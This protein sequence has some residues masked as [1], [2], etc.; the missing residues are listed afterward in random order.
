MA[1]GRE[2]GHEGH[3][4]TRPGGDLT[5]EVRRA[6]KIERHRDYAGAQTAEERQHPLGA[7]GTPKQRPVALGQPAALEQSGHLPGAL[8][9]VPIGPPLVSKAGLEQQRGPLSVRERGILK[10][11][12]QGVAQLRIPSQYAHH[13]DLPFLRGPDTVRPAA[14]SRQV[15]MHYPAVVR[16]TI[17][18]GPAGLGTHVYDE[19]L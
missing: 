2:P 11:L 8:P 4:G 6:A 17:S 13:V 15:Q 9:K 10:E 19:W 5:C 1:V 16:R 7:V 18:R 3:F 12:E 14:E